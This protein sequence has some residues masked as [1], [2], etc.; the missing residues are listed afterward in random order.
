MNFRCNDKPA[1]ADEMSG[2]RSDNN[3]PATCC[4]I[5]ARASATISEDAPSVE[6]FSN[7]SGRVPNRKELSKLGLES[8]KPTA[9]D[10]GFLKHGS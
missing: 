4:F 7:V 1:H 8:K 10:R 9:T 2:R 5:M 3:V 6:A